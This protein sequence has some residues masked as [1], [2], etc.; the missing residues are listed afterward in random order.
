M[1]KKIEVQNKGMSRDVS[2]SKETLEYAFENH[3]IRIQATDDNTLLSV[4]NIQGPKL[5]SEVIH[6][7][8]VN[9]KGVLVGKCDCKE[10][11]V[12][13][14]HD[15]DLSKD[16]IYRVDFYDSFNGSNDFL[17]VKLLY[18]GD[19]NFNIDHP[20]DTLY[21]IENLNV[22]K[23]YFTDGLNYP[24]FINIITEGEREGQLY[25][26][27]TQYKEE[28]KYKFEFYPSITTTPNINVEK[29]Y[30]IKSE[31]PSGTIQYFLSYYNYN[32]SESLIV[33]SSSI[34]TIDYENRGATAE[35]NGMCG[36]RITLSNL[37]TT[38]DC[39]RVYSAIRT[40]K[41]GSL[42]TKIVGDY[43]I[44]DKQIITLIDGGI[45][46]E[47]IDSSQLFFI[48]GNPFI[49]KTLTSKDN[50]IFF[51]N[52][53]TKNIN[54]DSEI[55]SYI[56]SNIET[57]ED[58]EDVHKWAKDIN[59]TRFNFNETP[60]EQE[61][62]INKKA[63]KNFSLSPNT[64]NENYNY[65]LQTSKGSKDYKTFKGGEIYRFGIQFQTE[66]GQWTSVIWIGDKKCESYPFVNTTDNTIYLNNAV[67]KMPPELRE[68]CKTIG[69]KNYRIVFAEA[70]LQNGRSVLTQGLVCPT[71]F[72][73][74][75]RALNAPYSLS[76]WIMRPR[77]GNV[78]NHHFEPLQ[79][80]EEESGAELWSYQLHGNKIDD[81]GPED[82]E[83]T[84]PYIFTPEDGY[85]QESY[86]VT[87]FSLD[88]NNVCART[89]KVDSS[90]LE[91]NFKD[92]IQ[93]RDEQ[94]NGTFGEFNNTKVE[95]I[96]D[97]SDKG[98]VNMKNGGLQEFHSAMRK[99]F[100]EHNL[101]P[102]YIPS[103]SAMLQLQKQI[104]QTKL[105]IVFT[106]IGFVIVIVAA[107]LIG[108][109]SGG[110]LGAE[111]SAAV[112][113]SVLSIC[114]IVGTAALGLGIASSVELAKSLDGYYGLSQEEWSEH[115]KTF[116]SMESWQKE[117][118]LNRYFAY[119]RGNT[120]VF[121]VGDVPNQEE[122]SL[123]LGEFPIEFKPSKFDEV[124]TTGADRQAIHMFSITPVS[125]MSLRNK[126]ISKQLNDYYVDES[127]VTFHSPEIENL[128]LNNSNALFRIVGIAPISNTYSDFNINTLNHYIDDEGLYYERLQTIKTENNLLTS[129]FLYLGPDYFKTVEEESETTVY[130]NALMKEPALYKVFMFDKSGSIVGAN[131]NTQI[132]G[133]GEDTPT[134]TE[135]P[136]I[137]KDKT[138]Y[139][140]QF[141]QQSIY[142]GVNDIIEYNP[143]ELRYFGG[144]VDSLQ[145]TAARKSNLY[146]GNYDHL[147]TSNKLGDLK[148]FRKPVVSQEEQILEE[149][150]IDAQVRLQYKSTPHLMFDLSDTHKG[151][152]WILP[153]F[154]TR[155]KYEGLKSRKELLGVAWNSENEVSKNLISCWTSPED[156]Y[157]EDCYFINYSNTLASWNPPVIEYDVNTDKFIPIFDI[158]AYRD[159][160]NKIEDEI[161]K[162]NNT[163]ASREQQIAQ[164][165][166]EKNNIEDE[167]EQD[168]IQ[169]EI[170][171]L[172][173]NIENLQAK[174]VEY[175]Y[176]KNNYRTITNGLA[177]GYNIDTI[178][179]RYLTAPEKNTAWYDFLNKG[180][181]III[182]V[183][184]GG[185]F[186]LNNF[187]NA[188]GEPGN[189]TYTSKN[190][191]KKFKITKGADSTFIENTFTGLLIEELDYTHDEE[192]YLIKNTLWDCR[193]KFIVKEFS[194]DIQG[195]V[196]GGIKSYYDFPIKYNVPEIK[197]DVTI[198]ANGKT[199]PYLFIG[200]LYN[201]IKHQELYG[202]YDKAQINNLI[203]YPAS[204]VTPID[205]D[206]NSMEGD[207]Y[208]Q[209]WDCL[210]TY[211]QTEENFE[212]NVVDVTSVMLE[213]HVNLDTR[214]DRNRGS[215]NMMS[216]PSNFNL[217]NPVYDFKNN[218]FTYTTKQ[219]DL[220]SNNYPNQFAWSMT[221]NYLARVDSW[222]NISLSSIS[223][224]TYPITKLVNYN[225]QILALTEHSVELINFNA[226]NLLPSEDGSFIELANSNKVDGT[227]KLYYH[228]GTYNMSVLETEVGLY[229]IDDNEKSLIRI[230]SEGISKLGLMKMDSWFK[231]NIVQGTFTYN[232]QKPFHLE[233]DSIH[234]DIYIINEDICLIYNETLGSFTSFIDFQET[235]G[236]FS[237]KG[238]VYAL[239][240]IENPLFYK[241][242]E[243]DYNT[244][245]GG[246]SIDYSMQ[247]RVNPSPISDKVFTNIEFIADLDVNP[248]NSYKSES[249]PFNYIRVWNEYQDTN[250]IPLKYTKNYVSNLKQFFRFW[251]ADI[252]RD[253][254]ALGGNRIRNPWIHLTI[255][256]KNRE[257]KNISK[258][259]FHNLNIQYI[260]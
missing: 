82:N 153:Y 96:F 68:L 208:F 229:F 108:L 45:N 218:I 196:S 180:K 60:E 51:G 248:L 167:N 197:K 13:F 193:Y 215:F 33:N 1:L 241:L 245:Y 93:N 228:Y 22:R 148:N 195:T 99:A 260:D 252:P 36:F 129:D 227:T 176:T 112:I 18:C 253:G 114:T 49:A 102:D 92:I 137:V 8:P 156:W 67:Y 178:L 209:R 14:T 23:V 79:A 53:T 44:K 41:D 177:Q 46:Q 56:E 145:Y 121:D 57:Q 203:W 206:V 243:G 192:L 202:G 230:T 172:Y 255:G 52:I 35:E 164:L 86:I 94:D 190:K 77:E 80:A 31:L 171:Y 186:A 204:G 9:L 184:Y 168:S 132:D 175:T 221:K 250:E 257:D 87:F 3:N 65:K 25:T 64:F 191:Y 259:E 110:I 240:Y 11:L 20:I 76:S 12:V 181:S 128:S 151:Q 47:T 84:K 61:Q 111:M 187:P 200:E 71:M 220:A 222:T 217:M 69:Y 63:Y 183:N 169:Q 130:H 19:L 185:E 97:S 119:K 244:T 147:I 144:D 173:Q 131:G 149:P 207:T 235:Q 157:Y 104:H 216:R 133:V 62:N 179:T 246:K 205:E 37:D 158:F 83:Y 103:L 39:V 89:V 238:G 59:F 247:Y 234:K 66:R 231:Q 30:T 213:S 107:I 101:N 48:G 134:F 141:S 124:N 43:D 142:F 201:N 115:I 50:T 182:G 135:L 95:I 211:P 118:L 146:Y 4:T 78:A 251:R 17:S 236:L 42:L 154:A 116:Q 54:I 188:N 139:N 16:F 163:I 98:Y 109:F 10:L 210:K 189:P 81:L 58:S 123:G 126:L 242:F 120:K 127:I 226:K 174:I 105:K 219:N 6:D 2:M 224:C 24:R 27:F 34:Y 21:F 85:E 70:E 143:S 162:L 140:H 138:F 150:R 5:V 254:N 237:F 233:Y 249:S 90:D 38:F 29:D 155:Q 258:M 117:F 223:N 198:Y 28:D 136:S 75:Q 106:I 88:S 160:Y 40:S 55:E 232:N 74:G 7:D 113:N 239:T 152:K 166:E 194:S 26:D 159:L 100:I 15:K 170:E 91:N 256:R 32:G 72:T 73:P 122:G 199:L 214:T 212:N 165:E 225:N 161:Q 125:N